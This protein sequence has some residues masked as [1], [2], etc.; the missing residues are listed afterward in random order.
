MEALTNVKIAEALGLSNF[1]VSNDVSKLRAGKISKRVKNSKEYAR[2]IKKLVDRKDVFAKDLENINPSLLAKNTKRS[3][4]DPE[5]KNR[6]EAL[7]EAVLASHSKWAKQSDLKNYKA[8][9][10][11]NGRLVL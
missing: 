6:E 10:M 7:I 4:I 1:L 3:I 5:R 11:N 9:S 2:V 8:D